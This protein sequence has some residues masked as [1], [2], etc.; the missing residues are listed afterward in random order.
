MRGPNLIKLIRSLRTKSYEKLYIQKHLALL[1]SRP[2]GEI[3]RVSSVQELD[4]R[5]ESHREIE[6]DKAPVSDDGP[7]SHGEA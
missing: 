4:S 6:P 7:N 5:I 3:D 1:A 2:S